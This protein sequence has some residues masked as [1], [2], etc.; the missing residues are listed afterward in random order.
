MGSIIK[1]VSNIMSNTQLHNA[2]NSN[3]HGGIN[4]YEI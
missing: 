1:D 4:T 3:V 2:F